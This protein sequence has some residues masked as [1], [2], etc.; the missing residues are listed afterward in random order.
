MSIPKFGILDPFSVLFSKLTSFRISGFSGFFQDSFVVLWDFSGFLE[1]PWMPWNSLRFLGN[2][3]LSFIFYFFL[4][5]NYYWEIDGI[6]LYNSLC[7]NQSVLTLD[8]GRILW[9]THGYPSCDEWNQTK[10]GRNTHCWGWTKK[11][12]V[13]FLFFSLVLSIGKHL[14]QPIYMIYDHYT[15]W[16]LV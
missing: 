8:F 11:G 10:F 9:E 6:F 15:N 12:N 1:I 2:I 3:Y 4:Q 13:Q 7:Q 5:A 16:T 14:W